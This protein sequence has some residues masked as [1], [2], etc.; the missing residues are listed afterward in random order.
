MRRV[1]DAFNSHRWLRV[2]LGLI[3][4][5]LIVGGAIYIWNRSQ[6]ITIKKLPSKPVATSPAATTSETDPVLYWKKSIQIYSDKDRTDAAAYVQGLPTNESSA[7]FPYW[8]N[9]N[10][11]SILGQ[12]QD[13]QVIAAIDQYVK[14]RNKLINF[15]NL[16]PIWSDFLIFGE[17]WFRIPDHPDQLVSGMQWFGVSTLYWRDITTKEIVLVGQCGN[18]FERRQPPEASKKPFKAKIKPPPSCKPKYQPKPKCKPVVAPTPRQ[19]EEEWITPTRVRNKQEGY[20][21]PKSSMTYTAGSSTVGWYKKS[22]RP[23]VEETCPPGQRPPNPPTDWCP[24]I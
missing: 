11:Y 10:F 9:D 3:V 12:L 7:I 6:P 19:H 15:A 23:K 17:V 24:D 16:E 13:P 20:S 4:A 8:V 1:I 2:A 21:S 18:F 5:V 14:S 22:H